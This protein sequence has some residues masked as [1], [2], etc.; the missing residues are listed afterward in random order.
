[1]LKHAKISI[2]CITDKSHHHE[3]HIISYT[4]NEV[5]LSSVQKPQ[6][7]QENADITKICILF[8]SC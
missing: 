8:L 4:S 3:P 6:K 2:L 7:G 5:N 1:M